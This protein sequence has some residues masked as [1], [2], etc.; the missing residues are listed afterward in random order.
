[1]SP[2]LWPPEA[3][4]LGGAVSQ[5]QHLGFHAW[6]ISGVAPHQSS[7]VQLS[8]LPLHTS[9]G[10]SVG[11]YRHH[12]GVF[13]LTSVRFSTPAVLC[14]P[15]RAESHP[16]HSGFHACEDSGVLGHQLEQEQPFLLPR[17]AVSRYCLGTNWHHLGTVM[18]T[19][20]T[21]GSSWP[22]AEATGV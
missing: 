5:P 11:K 20:P 13:R 6:E 1:M 2:P 8:L 7:H 4:T 18:L 19:P 12:S 21:I 3:G 14:D 22:G 16:Q 9:V 15:S 17:H 10:A